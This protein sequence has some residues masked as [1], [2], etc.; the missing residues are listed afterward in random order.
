MIYAG[1]CFEVLINVCIIASGARA[2]DTRVREPG[3][4]KEADDFRSAGEV[5]ESD[6][7][8]LTVRRV[9][10]PIAP[11]AVRCEMLTAR[12]ILPAKVAA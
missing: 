9:T 3:Y 1:N 4:S 8:C 11:H 10:L 2:L 6:D 7:R 12:N 5:D